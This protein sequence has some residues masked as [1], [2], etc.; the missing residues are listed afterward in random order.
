MDTKAKIPEHQ[1]VYEQ[2]RDMILRGQF[3]PGDP[4][5]IM[6]LTKKMSAGMTP[7]REALRRL[8]AEN[9]LNSLENRRIIVPE[10][11][12]QDIEDIYFLRL[13]VEPELARRAVQNI[14]IQEIENLAGID[15]D[16]NT[17]LSQGDVEAYLKLNNLF[18]FEI[19][20]A[21]Q[22][23]SLFHVAR[24]LWVQVGPSLRVVS[25]RYGTANLPDKHVDL[26][27]A[28]RAKDGEAAAQAMKD[29][30][31]QSLL[32]VNSPAKHNMIK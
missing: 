2:L 27:K 12:A 30:L 26:L 22:S 31:R 13:T 3:A 21:A 11:N 23:R 25:G 9:A 16:I 7:I 18:H 29:D 24:S 15:A 17:A 28:F 32:L 19:Y 6:G 20:K 4:L 14:G 1:A 10:L 5:T 8:T